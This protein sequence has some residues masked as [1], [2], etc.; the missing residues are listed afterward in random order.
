MPVV[1]HHGEQR[2]RQRLGLPKKTVAKL[3]DAAWQQGG[4]R[5]EFG[6]SQNKLGQP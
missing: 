1:T 4:R 2:V 6:G 5:E 3:A